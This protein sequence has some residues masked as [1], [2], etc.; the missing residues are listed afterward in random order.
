[1][2]TASGSAVKSLGAQYSTAGGPGQTM[3]ATPGAGGGVKMIVVSSGQL[4]GTSGS[5]PVM[6]SIPNQQGVKT[7]NM[8]AKPGGGSQIISS[9]G[10]Q[11][12]TLPAGQ[13]VLP[14]GT[15]TMMIGKIIISKQ[16]KLFY[17]IIR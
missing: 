2:T 11:I 6:V 8:L 15:Q 1:M 3:Y 4:S 16:T 17:V 10:G 9:G 14:G 5:R 7:V 12:L 13:G